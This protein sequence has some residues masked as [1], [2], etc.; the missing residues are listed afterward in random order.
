MPPAASGGA[1]HTT[2]IWLAVC[3]WECDFAARGCW[4][5][6]SRAGRRAPL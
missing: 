2:L 5:R 1:G 4:R 3:T 6:F